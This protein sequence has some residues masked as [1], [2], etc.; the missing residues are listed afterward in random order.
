MKRYVTCL[1]ALIALCSLFMSSGCARVRHA[2]PTDLMAKA[3]LPGMSGVRSYFDHPN[4]L[5]QESLLESVKQER[6]GDYPV[7]A[8]GVKAYPLLAI[9]GGAA[10]GAYGAGLLKG[11]SEEGS[12]P[13][14]KVVTGVSTGA[15]IAPYA[16]LGKE[17]DNDLER[18]YTTVST[19]DLVKQK[20]PILSLVFSNS[21]ASNA[22]LAKYIAGNV[23]EK[24]LAE[25]AREHRRG[26]RLFVGTANLDAKKF[27]VWDMGAIAC[28]GGPAAAELFQK[29][30]LASASIP[31]TFP[32]VY[33]DVEADGKPYDEMHVD[34]GTMT[35]VFYIFGL[36]KDM[37]EK[38]KEAGIDPEMF[39]PNLYVLRNGYL[40]SNRQEVKDTIPAITGRAL[41]TL[42]DAQAVGDIYRIYA[43]TL[44]RNGDFNLACI[45]ADFESKA[46]EFFDPDDM[47]RLF[48]RGYS[49]A[50]K[51]YPWRKTPPGMEPPE[52]RKSGTP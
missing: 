1:F 13:V 9:S 46:K 25:I 10:N 50:L 30:L 29:V 27:M 44:K 37:R 3:D 8:R 22:P 15:L 47:R 52:V 11:W 38:A 48:S 21:L 33:F 31:V 14:F 39:V 16:F 32:P 43:F 6:P 34:G 51:G 26:R 17:Y 24:V 2:V 5:V 4:P 12:R 7:N 36:L 28:K 35:Q 40:S 41:D 42:I 19:K 18:C 20:R 45:P 23:N 49:D